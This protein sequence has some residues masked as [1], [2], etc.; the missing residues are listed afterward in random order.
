[1]LSTALLPIIPLLPLLVRAQETKNPYYGFPI[2]TFTIRPPDGCDKECKDTLCTIPGVC[3]PCSSGMCTGDEICGTWAGNENW[4][5]LH[6]GFATDGSLTGCADH[7]DFLKDLNID[8]LGE[9]QPANVRKDSCDIE[10]EVIAAYTVGSE[11]AAEGNV[12][13]CPKGKDALVRQGHEYAVPLQVV[14]VEEQAASQGNGN[15]DD[16][17]GGDNDDDGN[18][19]DDNDDSDGNPNTNGN[20]GDTSGATRMIVGALAMPVALFAALML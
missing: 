3:L 19:L 6:Y 18:P 1:M 9:A 14:C 4:C 8:N 13:C 2:N 11:W 12:T 10:T 17:S 7:K 15:D 20:G 16:L 5:C